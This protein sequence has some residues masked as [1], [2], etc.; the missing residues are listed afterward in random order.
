MR[1]GDYANAILVLQ[2]CLQQEPGKTA[3]VKDLSLSYFFNKEY[4]KSLETIKPL[5]DREDADDQCYQIAGN[6]Y[7]ELVQLKECEKMYRKGIRRFPNSGALYCELGELLWAQQDY[8]AISE[9]EKGI[10]ADPS[11]PKN[12]YHAC[13]HYYLTT[14][15]VW[16]LFYG[17]IYLNMEPRNRAGAEIKTMLLEGYKK[18]FSD[19]KPESIN[20]KKNGFE[21]QF[22][23]IMYNQAG[24]TGRGITPESLTMIRTRFL[25]AWQ[26]SGRYPHRLFEYQQ[27]LA[28]EGMFPAYNQWLFGPAA[29]L[30][31][32][33]QWIGQ[34]N[35]EYLLFQQF[36]KD[37]IFKIPAGQFYH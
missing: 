37:R 3:Y 14:D 23:E 8:G 17:E 22:L 1:Q 18:L 29:S 13:R 7:K 27:Q 31:E 32:Y 5:L 16:S 15:K 12:Y 26:Q 33:N 36:Q 4:N 6:N 10:E 11:F 30:T 28:R 21:K 9:W 34:H 24:L 20:K 25:L 19:L 35:E 2:R